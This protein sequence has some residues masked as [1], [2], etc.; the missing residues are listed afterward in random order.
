MA[1]AGVSLTKPY[2]NRSCSAGSTLLL[3]SQ[4]TL[5]TFFGVKLLVP[6]FILSTG[7]ALQAHGQTTSA[8]VSSS[9]PGQPDLP[10]APSASPTAFA[11]R[12]ARL[13]NFT[14]SQLFLSRTDGY[15]SVRF[16]TR[17]NHNARTTNPRH[18]TIRKESQ[19]A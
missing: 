12:T 18:L 9:P 14:D 7:S 17:E 6:L 5:F 13:H 3:F 8:H 2:W 19:D 10:D 4:K 1:Q 16:I 15:S 11:S